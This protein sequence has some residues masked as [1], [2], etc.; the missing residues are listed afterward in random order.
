[1][2]QNI[3][4]QPYTIGDLLASLTEF[5]LHIRTH[6]LNDYGIQ[7]RIGMDCGSAISLVLGGERPCYEV[8]GKPILHSMFL[9]NE[10]EKHGGL[11]VS[12][13]IYLALRPRQFIFADDFPIAVTVVTGT[14]QNGEHDVY[15]SVPPGSTMT[16]KKHPISTL[17]NGYVFEADRKMMEQLNQVFADYDETVGS[18]LIKEE[19]LYGHES[20][21]GELRRISRN[22]NPMDALSSMNTSFSSEVAS[23]DIDV[24]S[25]S[26]LE[27]YSPLYKGQNQLHSKPNLPSTQNVPS[28]APKEA[29]LLRKASE[30]NSVRSNLPLNRHLS[31]NKEKSKSNRALVYSDF[32]ES[33][34]LL[35]SI[36]LSCERRNKRMSVSRNGP[37]LPGWLMA[38]KHSINNGSSELSLNRGNKCQEVSR[39]GSMSALDRLNATAR[40]VDNMLKELAG[41]DDLE[42][43]DNSRYED[44]EVSKFPLNYASSVGGG[45]VRSGLYRMG[46]ALSS[47]CQTDYD[48][49]E[50]E[51]NSD[52]DLDPATSSK[53]EEL[54]LALKGGLGDSHIS[55]TNRRTKRSKR[56]LFG[57]GSFGKRCG[58]TGD[59]ADGEESNCSSLAASQIFDSVRWKSVH[60][61]G[62]ENEYEFSNNKYNYFDDRF[63]YIDDE[64]D[65]SLSHLPTTNEPP[66]NNFDALKEMSK[67]A[68]D[69]QQN[70]GDYQ[71][72]SFEDNKKA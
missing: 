22:V 31:V 32:S 9:A 13:E 69:I 47:T 43:G 46:R 8:V 44:V 50:S 16:S 2:N 68:K 52:H 49:M 14:K 35:P 45:S 70:F 19:F 65:Q 41:V 23:I 30:S 26:E 36:G 20:P 39:N 1:M 55:S 27:W 38:S 58:D 6:I 25:D 51:N 71:L 53:L 33:E 7:L 28:P 4:D 34:N 63:E 21:E 37:K 67:L 11:I 72:A 15:Y 66:K 5:A 62:Y 61:I 29:N 64:A 18:D 10:S 42:I 24:E 12:E 54:K 3:H 59:E 48:N 17:I 40:R 56:G 60:S 57:F